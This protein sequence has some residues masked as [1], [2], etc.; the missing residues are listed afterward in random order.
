MSIFPNTPP[1][2]FAGGPKPIDGPGVS[3]ADEARLTRLLD[4]V[5]AYMSDGRWRTLREIA[6]ATGGSEASVSARL[7]D[8]RKPK[9][10]G[11]EVD[12]ERTVV[13]GVWRYRVKGIA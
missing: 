11:H 4:R 6:E 2:L 13:E 10:G 7:R 12:R 3:Q 9:H 1:P 5:R 8:L